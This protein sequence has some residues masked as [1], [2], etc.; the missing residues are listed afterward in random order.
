V[1]QLPFPPEPDIE[2]L[3]GYGKNYEGGIQQYLDT[4][5][6]LNEETV[7]KRAVIEYL[8]DKWETYEISYQ[9]IA[10]ACGDANRIIDH[11][12]S[13]EKSWQDVLLRIGNTLDADIDK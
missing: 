8:W 5:K 7:G 2:Q 1:T 12:L 13:D 4:N 9:E 10:I 3:R 11:W 6:Q